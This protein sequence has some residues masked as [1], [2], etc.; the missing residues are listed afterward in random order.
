MAKRKQTKVPAEWAF[1]VKPTPGTV[2]AAI[3]KK[4]S[5]TSK[6]TR[7]CSTRKY[8]RCPAKLI[9]NDGLTFV[10]MCSSKDDKTPTLTPV[11]D[12][13][14]AARVTRELCA[15]WKTTKGD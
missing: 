7:K 4:G 11:K 9:V 12:G 14:E 3:P 1:T 5:N 6:P 15:T 2:T 10:S 8:Q 13:R